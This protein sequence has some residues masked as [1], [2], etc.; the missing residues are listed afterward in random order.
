MAFI[1]NGTT[2]LD[3]GSFASGAINAAQV[4]IKELTA[5]SSATLSFV[6]GSSSVVLDNTYPIYMFRFIDMHPQ[7]DDYS[8]SFQGSTDTG[9]SYGVTITSTSFR[10]YNQENDGG[11]G[12]GYLTGYDLAQSANFQ[13]LGQTVG[14]ANDECISG[15]LFLFN[16]SSN[17]FVKNFLARNVHAGYADYA[18]DGYTSGYFNTTSPIDAIQFKFASGNIDSGTIKLY[19]IKD[20]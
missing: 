8:F 15:E 16:P 9:G 17:T 14:N 13:R 19:G 1:S 3:A 12:L 5:S 11:N 6:D 7:T 20:S 2:I 10:S 4:L 18:G